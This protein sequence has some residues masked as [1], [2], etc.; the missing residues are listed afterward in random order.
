MVA[1]IVGETRLNL[2]EEGGRTLDTILTTASIVVVEAAMRCRE[3][4]RLRFVLCWRCLFTSNR[5]PVT[6]FAVPRQERYGLPPDRA[7][8]PSPS[9]AWG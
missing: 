4:T 6:L 8:M 5:R 7:S 2:E 3:W 9:K 1:F